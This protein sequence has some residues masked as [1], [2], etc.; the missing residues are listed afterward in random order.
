MSSGTW[1]HIVGIRESGYLKLYVNG[2]ED[3]TAVANAHH[4]QGSLDMAIGG[5]ADGTSGVNAKI[6]EVSIWRRALSASA[7]SYT[8]LTLPTIYS[9]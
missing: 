1:Y 2:S 8:H 4:I 9:V 3:A 5:K 7:V 6:D